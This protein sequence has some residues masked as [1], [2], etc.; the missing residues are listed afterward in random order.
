MS[1]TLE[2]TEVDRAD[3]IVF[4]AQGMVSSLGL[5]AA[6]SC[7]AAR[8]GIRRAQQIDGLRFASLD[9]RSV[10]SATGHPVPII[11]HGFEGAARLAQLALAAVRDL[12]SRFPISAGARVGLY[13]SLPSCRRH[14]TGAELIPDPVAKKFFLEEADNARLGLDESV[15]TETV[16]APAMKH[17]GLAG[18]SLR[19]AT[20][21]GHTGF[22]EALAVAVKEVQR[23][24]VDLA[25][26]G[27]IDSLV[28]E[29]SLKWLKLTGRLKSEANPIGLE[30]GEGAAFIAIERARSMNGPGIPRFS[31]IQKIA[32]GEEVGSQLLGQPV[33][34]KVLGDCVRAIADMAET[35]WLVI[36][37]NGEVARGMEFGNVLARIE[38]LALTMAPV[39]FPA[40]SFGDT[41]AAS[42]AIAAC[43]AR[44]ALMR[45]YSNADAAAVA[46]VA[47]GSHRSAFSIACS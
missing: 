39:L 26:V 19:F 29:R 20:H 35:L 32:T 33:T 31:R 36:D 40:A 8:A 14:L 3:P 27:G 28:D 47:D 7:A 46:S 30:P 5:D 2:V 37:H 45:N 13:I 24:D 38:A 23:N 17:V 16:L 10:E 9:G 44:S 12:T 41:G 43:L 42:G 1:R 15:W 21:I 6:T 22:A 4:T 11:T 18:R 25:L 34:G